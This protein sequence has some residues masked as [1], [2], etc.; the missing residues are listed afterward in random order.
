MSIYATWLKI[1]HPSD[2]MDK[3]NESGVNASMAGDFSEEEKLGSPYVYQGSHVLPAT[4][5]PRGGWVEIA[6]IP[7]HITRDGRDD[8][9]EGKHDWLRVTV[10]ETLDQ[11]GRVLLD[12]AQVE[13]LRNTLT[14]WLDA[15]ERF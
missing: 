9:A 4:N 15:K 8:G 5:D 13:A 3:L 11:Q 1:E 6:A 7:N 10:G 14:E 12:R 2:W